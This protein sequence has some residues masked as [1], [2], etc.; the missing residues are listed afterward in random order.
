M[1][2]KEAR[3]C[4]ICEGY[5]EYDYLSALINKNVFQDK[6]DIKLINAKSIN[7]LFIR[8][9]EKYQS[10]SYHLILIFCDTDKLSATPYKEL[11][12]KINKFHNNLTVANSVII[13]GNPCTMQIILS[14]FAKVSLKSSSKNVNKT[15]IESLTG[16]KNYKAEEN[17][18]KELMNKI[19]QKNYKIMKENLTDISQDDNN[20]PSTNFLEFTSYFESE[21]TNWINTIN[22]KL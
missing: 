16:I 21:T 13:F 18:R 22:E 15:L 7:N 14:H 2:I 9:I 11:K 20:I 12:R 17:Q 6:Y 5:E 10:D 8:Y 1:K 4:I 19:T 3:I